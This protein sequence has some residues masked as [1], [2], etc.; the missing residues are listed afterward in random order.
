MT[1]TVNGLPKRQSEAFL[2]A[3]QGLTRNETASRMGCSAQN[4]KMLI[5]EVHNKLGA[6]NT[7]HAI[8]EAFRR[9][10]LRALCLAMFFASV[11][12]VTPAQKALAEEDLMARRLRSR[13]TQRGTRRV[14]GSR[15]LARTR[16]EQSFI[17]YFGLETLLV[18]DEDHFYVAHQRAPGC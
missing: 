14:R 3:A 4:V 2:Y 7:P 10:I 11:T 16:Q 5:T 9:G 8:S 18:W 1:I 15:C 13:S 17:D 6:R 12:A